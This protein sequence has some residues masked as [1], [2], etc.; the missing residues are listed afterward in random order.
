MLDYLNIARADSGEISV[1]DSRDKFFA[2]FV[3]NEWVLG[4]RFSNYEFEERLI[5]VKDEQEALR[6]LAEAR[7][8]LNK[9]LASDQ[10][11]KS[12]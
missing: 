4:H 3:G 1:Y 11:I 12:A 10:Q 5:L 7:T 8:A 2:G 9:P 6:I